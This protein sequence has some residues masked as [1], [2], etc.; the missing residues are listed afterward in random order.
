MNK[1]AVSALAGLTLL[2]TVGWLWSRDEALSPLAKVWLEQAAANL[3]ESPA[4]YQLMGMDAPAGRDPQIEGHKRVA[5]YHQR[6]HSQ[7]AHPRTDVSPLAMPG[8]ALCVLGAQGCLQGLRH[9][10]A[11][12]QA[13]LS[14][15]RELLQRYQQLLMLDAPHTVAKLGLDEPI[16]NYAAVLWGNRLRSLQALQL[17]EEGQGEDALALLQEDVRLLRVWLSNADN[18]I[19]KMATVTLV[20]QN[21]D[22]LA[23]LY[24]AGLIPQ[25]DI[26]QPLSRDERSLLRA[27]QREFAMVA[28]G[29]TEHR[30]QANL[31]QELGVSAWRLQW[32]YKPQMS[33]NDSLPAYARLASES[34]LKAEAFVGVLS[35]PAPSVVSTWRRVRNPVGRILVGVAIPDFRP[36]LAR[37]HDLDAKLVLFNRLGRPAQVGGNPYQPYEQPVWD[38][39]HQRMCFNGPLP[40]SKQVR[41]LPAN[42]PL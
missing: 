9:E 4:Y 22:A 18:L 14:Q 28:T 39:K 12:R 2:I 33:I 30:Y 34:L 27:M 31:E 20:A 15:H 17:A 19:M 1:W 35:E 42:Q 32:V 25:P 11:E 40:D 5:R 7:E 23:V 37:L 38:D 3:G 21:L 10:P 6:L 16:P 13:L 36:Y 29:L 24:Q 26:Q 41:C 8:D